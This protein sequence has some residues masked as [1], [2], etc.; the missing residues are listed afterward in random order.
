VSRDPKSHFVGS[1]S[2]T[3]MSSRDISIAAFSTTGSGI[4]SRVAVAA[5][6]AS[7]AVQHDVYPLSTR[8]PR[9]S[10]QS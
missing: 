9:C 4:R 7:R 6:P 8:G 5:A 1:Q 3:T 2:L 10:L